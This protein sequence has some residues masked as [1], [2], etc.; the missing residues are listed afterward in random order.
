MQWLGY[1]NGSAHI[2]TA[3]TGFAGKQTRG[4]IDRAAY[5]SASARPSV[6]AR[7]VIAMADYDEPLT[8]QSVPVP[9]LVV[10]A[11]LDRMTIPEA[12]LA[13]ATKAPSAELVRLTPAG[14][15]GIWEQHAQFGQT[16][17]WF[18]NRCLGGRASNAA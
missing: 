10:T 18:A 8:L 4:Q 16:L 5:L 1:L 13:M 17:I 9:V 15:Q 14:H 7:G 11:N 12:S 6:V 3:L 2:E